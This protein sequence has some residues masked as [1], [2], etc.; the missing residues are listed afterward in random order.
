MNGLVDEIHV[1]SA[2]VDPGVDQQ[3][4]IQPG[5]G[6]NSFTKRIPEKM[7]V[8]RIWS[9]YPLDF[10][11]F[12]LAHTLSS[13]NGWRSALDISILWLTWLSN[14][15][16]GR[17]LGYRKLENWVKEVDS[18]SGLQGTDHSITQKEVKRV[19]DESPF[20]IRRFYDVSIALDR[21]EFQELLRREGYIINPIILLLSFLMNSSRHLALPI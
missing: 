11:Q 17:P 4:W 20:S 9:E 7:G 19:T 1:F 5:V 12:S 21:L 2:A 6:P 15:N 18:A 8:T 10:A 13:S 3:G 16:R 14:V